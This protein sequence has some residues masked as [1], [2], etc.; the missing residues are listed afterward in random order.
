MYA[1]LNAQQVGSN[2]PLN[3]IL[4]LPG[5]GVT[6]VTV[7]WTIKNTLTLCESSC[8]A[9]FTVRY[10]CSISCNNEVTPVLCYGASTG[11]ITVNAEGGTLPYI[12]NLYRAGD[13]QSPY[14]TAGPLNTGV[15]SVLFDNLPAG[16]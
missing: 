16:S 10:G 2:A 14:R 12:V 11:S 5:V 9:T 4:G 13:P 7:T 6:S 1:P 8:S 15:I 3:P